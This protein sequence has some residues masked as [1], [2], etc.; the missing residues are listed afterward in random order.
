MKQFK[1]AV[2]SIVR[3]AKGSFLSFFVVFVLA[4][5]LIMAFLVS[6]SMQNIRQYIDSQLGAKATI[7]IDQDV[8]S[9]LDSF[10]KQSFQR[11]DEEFIKNLGEFDEVADYDYSYRID[12]IVVAKGVKSTIKLNGSKN[13]L[14]LSFT[15][16]KV[17]LSEGRF[18]S[19]QEISEDSKVA[20]IS[21]QYSITSGVIIGDV[22]SVYLNDQEI[23]HVGDMNGQDKYVTLPK[24]EVVELHVIGLFK[25]VQSIN[26]GSFSQENNKIYLS[27][28]TVKGMIQKSIETMETLLGY[29]M[30]NF[31]ETLSQPI[32][33]LKDASGSI[34]F[35]SKV[36]PL[37]PYGYKVIT[38]ATAY[39]SVV[40]SLNVLT[41]TGQ[42]IVIASVVLLGTLFALLM[43]WRARER[44]YE[45]GILISM[46]EKKGKILTQLLFESWIIASLAI[47]LSSVGGLFIAKSI[48]DNFI[49]QQVSRSNSQ[50]A[51]SDIGDE[52]KLS[53]VEIAQKYRVEM[54]PFLFLELYI[55]INLIVVLSTGLTVRIFL[56]TNPWKHLTS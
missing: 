16:G 21:S 55:F 27:N 14:P 5:V 50:I 9:S 2:T 3:N 37:L 17:T 11:I 42:F 34:S 45:L 47:L 49:T 38:L 46:G 24:A 33:I 12:S 6:D 19:P 51:E 56:N 18:F 13:K 41:T 48:T 15:E 44:K 29:T 26:S 25:P 22:I 23:V 35:K 36:E 52:N 43:I 8:F 20:L 30:I 10:E 1:R 4:T 32:F 31:N 7:Q 40:G 53:L 39:D 28:A 54:D